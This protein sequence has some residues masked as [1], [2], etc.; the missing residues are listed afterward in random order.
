ILSQFT[1]CLFYHFRFII[2]L[3][4]H[5]CIMCAHLCK[6]FWFPKSITNLLVIIVDHF[7]FGWIQSKM[8]GILMILSVVDRISPFT[9]ADLCLLSELGQRRPRMN[10][11]LAKH[12]LWF[13]ERNS[14]ESLRNAH[15]VD[16][17]FAVA[18]AHPST[19]TH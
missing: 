3:Y 17:I 14:S 13:G 10:H 2:F 6:Y 19:A 1:Y 9:A 18:Y 16:D 4:I 11:I 12:V 5:Q 7:I 15:H 8:L